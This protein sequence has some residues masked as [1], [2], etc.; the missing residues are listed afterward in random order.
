MDTNLFPSA[1]TAPR[2]AQQRAARADAEL[3]TQIADYLA[4]E[5]REEVC[6]VHVLQAEEIIAMVR[7]SDRELSTGGQ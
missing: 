6:R 2:A 4:A 7:E 5:N 3:T 1:L